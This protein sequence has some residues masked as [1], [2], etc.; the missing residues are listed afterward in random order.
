M[1]PST[2][3]PALADIARFAFYRCYRGVG[4]SIPEAREDLRHAVEPLH[5]D[6]ETV[7]D[8]LTCLSELTTNA[9]RHT[10]PAGREGF[11]VIAVGRAGDKPR[12]R[13]EVHDPDAH[14]MPALPPPEP[15]EIPYDA[16][17]GRGLAMVAALADGTGCD[18][19]PCWKVVWC[20]LLAERHPVTA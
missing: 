16:T 5:L 12:L 19:A 9:I 4:A 2:D 11:R 6:R 18:R 15:E 14:R 20:E 13:L 8:A 1:Y 7:E 3:D 17:S 10:G